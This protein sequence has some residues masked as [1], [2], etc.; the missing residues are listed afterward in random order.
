MP[1]YRILTVMDKKDKK[2]VGAT[3]GG[4]AGGFIGAIV[5]GPVGALIGSAVASWVGHKIADS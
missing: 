4:A 3:V 2:V 5:A 1:P